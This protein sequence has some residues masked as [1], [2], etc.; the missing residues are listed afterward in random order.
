MNI[1]AIY[2]PRRTDLKPTRDA[3]IFAS[4]YW[5]CGSAAVAIVAAYREITRWRCL[6]CKDAG[7]SMEALLIQC[8]ELYPAP[9]CIHDPDVFALNPV[10][11]EGQWTAYIVAC[12][13][14]AWRETAENQALRSGAKLKEDHARFLFADDLAGF[15]ERLVYRS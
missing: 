12:T 8:G 9:I 6:A 4:Q 14:T 15:R 11:L 10:V 5:N 3:R 13:D 7:G 2:P 1:Q